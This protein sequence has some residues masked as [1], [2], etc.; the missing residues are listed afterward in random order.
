MARRKRPAVRSKK[1]ALLGHFGAANF[2]NEITLQAVLHNLRRL[3]PSI[4]I[5]CICTDADTTA[6]T[7]YVEA[8]ALTAPFMAAWAPRTPIARMVR[9]TILVLPAEV[10]RLVRG[11]IVLRR[12]DGLI[13]S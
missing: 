9:W 3:Q 1:V 8:F 2:G 12:T 5:T 13:V 6:A 4:A 10:Y 7:H 11:L